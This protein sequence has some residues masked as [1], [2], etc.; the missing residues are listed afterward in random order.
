ML[1]AVSMLTF[2]GCALTSR[3]QVEPL[4]LHPSDIRRP[5][6]L[7]D[8]IG[9]GDYRHAAEMAGSLDPSTEPVEELALLGRAQFYCGRYEAAIEILSQALERRM[10]PELRARITWD[11]AQIA[12]Q[13]QD[14]SEALELA[15]EAKNGGIRIKGWYIHLLEAIQGI[16]IHAVEGSR[17]SV[18]QFRFGSPDLPRI[19]MDVNGSVTADA[20]L[21]TGAVMSIVSGSF[22]ER[23]GIRRL[24]DFSGEFYGLL[25][26][27]IAV[28][29]GLIDSLEI[30]GITIRN[31][32]VAI[33]EDSK[34]RFLVAENE[35]FDIEF[36]VGT[37]FMKE[38]RL[39][40]DYDRQQLILD[41]LETPD[42]LPVSNQNLFLVD[43]RPLVHV[44]IN[45]RGWYPFLLDSGSEV[46]FLNRSRFTI[47]NVTYGVPRYHGATMQGL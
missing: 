31:V 21:D 39:R 27:P 41:Y 35:R 19:A 45:G 46:T 10:T 47:Q 28:Q 26:E 4:L 42:R 29:F 8:A 16:R 43:Q 12:Y 33:M 11:L 1:L 15:L 17:R 20:V 2:S 7:K 44:T 32:P 40:F 18:V 24:G 23:A 30:S 37:S 6:S 34:L 13:Q 14:M 9:R 5:S 25:G 36:L 3:V 38:F 22:A